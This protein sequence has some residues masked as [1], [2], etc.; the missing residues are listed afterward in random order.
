[1]SSVSQRSQAASE[2]RRSYKPELKY[3]PLS[4]L[5]FVYRPGRRARKAQDAQPSN[6]HV[7]AADDYSVAYAKGCEY[8]AHYLQFIKDNPDLQG[9]NTIGAIL[10]DM[11]YRDNSNN[12]GYMVGFLCY[13][14]RVLYAQ[15]LRMDAY[16]GVDHPQVF[17]RGGVL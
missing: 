15:S 11:D 13:L 8:A 2:G 7:P 4:A 3:Q 5:P 9:A 12:A 17:W 16:L 1:M 14:E 10:Q 6:W